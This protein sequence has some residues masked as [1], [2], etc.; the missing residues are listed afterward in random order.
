MGKAGR[1]TPGSPRRKSDTTRRKSGSPGPGTDRPARKGA[2]PVRAA[3]TPTARRRAGSVD[4]GVRYRDLVGHLP[5]GVYRTTLDGAILE[6]NQTIADMLGFAGPD[7]LRKVKVQDLY[8]REKDRREHIIALAHGQFGPVEFRLARHDGAVLWVRDYCRPV[9]DSQ[10]VVRF[11]DG[12]LVDI[13][14]E[15]R[16]REA[17]RQ[18]ERDY[19]ELFENA[20]DAIMILSGADADGTILEANQRACELYGFPRE[21]FVG[22][23]LASLAKDAELGR[24]RFRAA[25]APGARTTFETVHRRR[26]GTE[27]ALEVNAAAVEHR[28]QPAVLSINRDITARRAL[29]QTI[30]EMA[31]HDPLTGLPNR[32]LLSDRL[33]LALAQARR[34]RR[35][36]AVLFLDL[37]GFKTVND[38]WGHAQ[39][40]ALLRDVAGRLAG[41]L[42][43]GDT[44]ARI[45]GDE[46]TVLIPELPQEEGAAEVSRKVLRELERTF[47]VGRSECRV[48]ASIGIALYPRDGE[49]ADTLLKHAD[50]AMYRAKLAGGDRFA[51]YGSPSA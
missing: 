45:G 33:D 41:A 31:F 6:A 17:L 44:V 39:G 18:S 51:W 12:I 36:M 46:F 3:S 42:R 48:T 29:E 47:H 20:H 23:P 16:A 27:M 21:E 22:M 19:R 10:G 13:T 7:D 4:F 25:L 50:A 32:K 14:A 38:G 11:Y 49:D 24:S 1:R 26:D 30:R 28:G 37:D 15:K 43:T 40:D 35:A 5:V 2:S 34:N 9:T 8:V